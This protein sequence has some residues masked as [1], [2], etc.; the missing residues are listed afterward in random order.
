MSDKLTLKQEAFVR[1]YLQSGNASEAYRLSYDAENMTDK[2]VWEESCKLLKH[3]KV[4]ARVHSARERA[5]EKAELSRA[6]VLERLMKN[7]R[8]ALAEE[9]VRLKKSVKDK[10]TG[11][12]LVVE[13]EVTD[14]DT[15]GA[16][17]ALELLGKEC[18]MFVDRT[19]I[20]SP[21]EFD[22]MGTDELREFVAG[23][24]AEAGP[25]DE[26]T[27]KTRGSRKAGEQ[28]N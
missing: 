7:A 15:A 8:I 19:E 24:I 14:R 11:T 28:L 23:R 12:E 22:M 4:S 27:R 17:K 10:E 16:N 26:G 3:P 6:W 2:T 18:G 5:N 21:G 1:A 20:G 9:T 13:V 25:R